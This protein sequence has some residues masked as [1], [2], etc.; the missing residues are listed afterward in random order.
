[1]EWRKATSCRSWLAQK[2]GGRSYMQGFIHTTFCGWDKARCHR[3]RNM[4]QNLLYAMA[5]AVKIWK[6][7]LSGAYH[8]RYLK[9]QQTAPQ[10]KIRSEV[11]EWNKGASWTIFDAASDTPRRTRNFVYNTMKHLNSYTLHSGVSIFEYLQLVDFRM[12]HFEPKP[13]HGI[14]LFIPRICMEIS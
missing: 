5:W 1:M 4:T 8:R 10:S 14:C 11:S 3:R 7:Q 6:I 2:S 9:L 13:Y 12:G